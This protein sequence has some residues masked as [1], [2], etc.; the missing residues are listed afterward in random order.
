MG[1]GAGLY[2]YV[3]VVQKFTFAISYPDEFL[4]SNHRVIHKSCTKYRYW[5]TV[6]LYWSDI[7]ASFIFYVIF[8]FHVYIML[9]DLFVSLFLW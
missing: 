4:V 6:P 9:I 1:V 3:V 8:V 7:G 2:M 5:T